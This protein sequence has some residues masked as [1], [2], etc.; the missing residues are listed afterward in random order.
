MAAEHAAY[1]A[2]DLTTARARANGVN[3]QI[4]NVRPTDAPQ[5][6]HKGSKVRPPC[7]KFVIHDG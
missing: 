2:K 3:E 4:S 6:C 5:L 7:S 1:A